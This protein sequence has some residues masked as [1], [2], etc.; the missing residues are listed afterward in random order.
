MVPGTIIRS[1][2]HKGLS[3]FIAFDDVSGLQPATV[4]KLRTM[5]S[6][7]QDMEHKKELR[8]IPSWRAHQLT[9]NL[10]GVWSLFVTQVQQ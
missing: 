2:K 1:V 10:K 5:I 3:H 4:E 6:F 7:L 8:D 9:G